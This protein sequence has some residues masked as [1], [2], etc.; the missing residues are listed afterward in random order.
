MGVETL[1]F[2]KLQL[3]KYMKH[4][5]FRPKSL[6]TKSYITNLNNFFYIF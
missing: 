4:V 1:V 2:N 5:L 3:K 6:V